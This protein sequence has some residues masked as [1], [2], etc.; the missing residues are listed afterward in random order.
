M[1]GRNDT[2]K[3]KEAIRKNMNGW[4]TDLG[5]RNNV[6]IQ[7]IDKWMNEGINGQMDERG[8][9]EKRD[10]RDLEIRAILSS[11]PR[12]RIID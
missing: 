6:R 7:N 2:G 8:K 10:K 1:D 9:I 4:M 5:K 12:R 11:N 3:K